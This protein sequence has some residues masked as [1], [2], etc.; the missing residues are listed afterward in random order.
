MLPVEVHILKSIKDVESGHPAKD[1]KRQAVQNPGRA[2]PMPPHCQVAGYRSYSQRCSEPE[3]GP[4]GESLS[5]AVRQNPGQ[6][7]GGKLETEWVEHCRGNDESSR[8][9]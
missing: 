9:Q 8:R 5:V 3:V 2:A 4:V 7:D 6:G 1:C